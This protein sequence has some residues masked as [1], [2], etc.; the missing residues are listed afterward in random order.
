MLPWQVSLPRRV[1]E[2]V[3]SASRFVKFK[4]GHRQL[5]SGMQR[6]VSFKSTASSGRMVS[7]SSTS[8]TSKEPFLS[9]SH[10]PSAENPRTRPPASQEAEGGYTLAAKTSRRR[11]NTS[12][13]TDCYCKVP[14][15]VRRLHHELHEG[16]IGQALVVDNSALEL[17]VRLAMEG[18]NFRLSRMS[19]TPVL[20]GLHQRKEVTASKALEPVCQNAEAD[21]HLCNS[22]GRLRNAMSCAS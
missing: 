8:A 1:A 3:N 7:I 5:L 16:T 17:H 22:G 13:A 10:L 6:S 20:E 12:T 15:A 19:R 18:G 2:T 21:R 11:R 4:G 9:P 14:S